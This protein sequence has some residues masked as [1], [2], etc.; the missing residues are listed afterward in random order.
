MVVSA[1]IAT[2]VL[3]GQAAHAK[4]LRCPKSARI[5]QAQRQM[6]EQQVAALGDRQLLDTQALGPR[7]VFPLYRCPGVVATR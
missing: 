2:T 5:S 7:I 1:A 6:L 3:G 4:P